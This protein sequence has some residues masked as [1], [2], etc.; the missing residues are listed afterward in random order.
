MNNFCVYELVVGDSAFY[1]GVTND[2]YHRWAKHK[3]DAKRGSI[4]HVH[5]KMRVLWQEGK[6]PKMNVLHSNLLQEDALSLEAQIIALYGKDRLCNETSGGETRPE[7][8]PTPE[9]VSLGMLKHYR[10][11]QDSRVRRIRCVELGK[12]FPSIMEAC[13]ELGMSRKAIR[14]RLE[15]NGYVVNKQ[16]INRT[17]NNFHFEFVD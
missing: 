8:R 5:S 15:H 14:Y 2:P 3:S 7:G 17:E 4:L 13:R 11:E 1:I 6:E 16:Q 10:T 9:A 12:I